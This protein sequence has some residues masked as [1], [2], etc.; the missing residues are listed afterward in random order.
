VAKRSA[1]I[2]LYRVKRGAPEVLLVHPGGPFWARRDAG[3]WSIPKGEYEP[4][5]DPGASA[6]REFEEETGSALSPGELIDLGSVEQ[7]G[8][9]VVSA[10]A[11]EGD[12]DPASVRSNSF[13]MQWPPRSGRQQEF[14]EIDRAQWF[15]L[16]EAREKLVPAQAEFLDRLLERLRW[17]WE[18][19]SR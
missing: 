5:D 19:K 13:T 17:P 9:K 6:L 7:K 3:A 2:L 16:G 10:W 14:P 4:G 18:R 11:S 12:L 1:G 15:T 8:G